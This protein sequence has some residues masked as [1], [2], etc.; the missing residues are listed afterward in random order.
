MKNKELLILYGCCDSYNCM[1]CTSLDPRL[2]TWKSGSM[3][4]L[5]STFFPIHTL[6]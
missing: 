5:N 3:I 2:E 4:S 1:N 6:N